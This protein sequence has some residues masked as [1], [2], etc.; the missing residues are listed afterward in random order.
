MKIIILGSGTGVPSLQRHS[1][2]NWLGVAGRQYLIDCGSGTLL[3]LERAGL[4]FRDLDGAF[5]THVHADH[6]GDLTPMVHAMRLPGLKREKP[7]LLYGPPG[8]S[9]F[10]ARI[11][12]PVAAPPTSFPFEI[13]DAPAS[14]EMTGVSIR[15]LSTPHSERFASRAYRFEHQGRAVVFSGDTDDTPELAAFLTD[16]DLAILECSTLDEAKVPGHLS[17]GLCGQR[18]AQAGVRR[19]LLNHFYPIEGPESQFLQQCRRHYAGPLAL[20]TDLMAL[21][22]GQDPA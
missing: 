2:A 5:I 22:V 3:Q 9:E 1:P 7:F 17:A 15:T 6:I 18:A 19:L 16:A 4:S 20:A 8:F 11:V 10:F 13:H 12:A 21:T 14:W